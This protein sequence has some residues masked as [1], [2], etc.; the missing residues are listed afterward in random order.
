MGKVTKDLNTRF[1]DFLDAT[2][3][4]WLPFYILFPLVRNA[5]DKIRKMSG[6]A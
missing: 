1:E 2:L 3:W 5:K 6:R 4:L